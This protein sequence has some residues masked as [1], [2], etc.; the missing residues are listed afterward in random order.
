MG[1]VAPVTLRHTGV[2]LPGAYVAIG[3][4]EMRLF[5]Q[6]SDLTFVNTSYDIWASHPDRVQG[7]TPAESRVLKYDFTGTTDPSSLYDAA[8]RRLKDIFPFSIDQ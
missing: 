2:L 7:K 1:I 4:N 5:P 6:T 8:Y 3:R